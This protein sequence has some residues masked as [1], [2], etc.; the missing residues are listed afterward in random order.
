MSGTDSTKGHKD[1][2]WRG[3][4]F[5][6]VTVVLGVGT[7]RLVQLLVEQAAASGGNLIVASRKA[8]VLG[9]LMTLRT[10][11]SLTLVQARPRH[12]PLLAETVDLLVVSGMLRQVPESKI[13]VM[14]DELWRTLVP[15]G[16]LRIADILEPSEAEYNLAWAVRNRIVGKMGN[17]LNRPT[18]VSVNVKRAALAMRSRGFDD[19][20][21]S[22]LPGFGLT[23]AWLEG[24]VNA[25]RTMASR[26]VDRE[27]RDD[28][29]KHDLERLI[30]AFHQG[31]QR[32]AERFVLRGTKAGHLALDMEASFRES[33]LFESA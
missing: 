7:G 2:T 26:I 31:E 28:I 18:A 10:D 27:L 32:A 22:I 16:Q 8:A 5:S 21:V 1:A 11:T 12:I 4:D 13:D 15:G 14:V 23:Q 17:A 29:L 24:T 20:K 25:A 30:A 9:T 19:L 3:V 6:G 33:D